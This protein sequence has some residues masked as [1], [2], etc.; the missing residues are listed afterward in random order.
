MSVVR[1]AVDATN[2]A[3]DRRGMGRIARAVLRVAARDERTEIV[4]LARRRDDLALRAEFPALAVQRPKTARRAGRY[5]VVWYPFNGMRFEASAP[6]LVTIHDAF[7]FTEPHPERIA[8]YREQAPI[9][10]AARRATR[11]VTDSNW[12][13]DEIARELHVAPARIDVALPEP[14][15]FWSAGSGGELPPALVAQRFALIVG[16]GE[17]RK[18]IR[19]AIDACARALHGPHE[20]LVVVGALPPPLRAYARERK[21]R[22]GEIAASDVMLRT[23]YRRARVVLVP[24]LGEGFG[25]I[26]VEALACGAPLL[27]ARAGALPEAVGDAAPLLDPNDPELWARAVRRIFDD[28]AHEADLRAAAVARFMSR[29]RDAG[30]ART[31]RL[32]HDLARGA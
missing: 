14:D 5:D 18:N 7:A 6:T 4:L 16:A 26:A 15:A 28:D 24:S 29:D 11:L 21:L 13:R 17:A 2:L 9:R 22:C 27:A 3:R 31:L 19:L 30:A 20:M 23:L 8:R 25:L 1:V 10:R 32:L 12:S